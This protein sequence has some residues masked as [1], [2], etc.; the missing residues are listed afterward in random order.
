MSDMEK[1]R[2]TDGPATA[3]TQG[4]NKEDGAATNKGFDKR[5]R[6]QGFSKDDFDTTEAAADIHAKM[7]TDATAATMYVADCMQSCMM[8]HGGMT[9]S[10]GDFHNMSEEEMAMMQEQQAMMMAAMMQVEQMMKE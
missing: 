9:H 4:F 3:N 7:G 1:M 2:F 8:E 5:R 10:T 6:L